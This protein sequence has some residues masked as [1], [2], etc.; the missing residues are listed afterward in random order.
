MSE[1]KVGFEVMDP[2]EVG[3]LSVVREQK[4]LVPAAQNVRFK[5][6]KAS[7]GENKSKDLK[8][9]KLE[10]RIVDGIPVNNQ[11]T[12]QVELKY[13]NKPM[14]TGVMDLVLWAD[15]SVKNR[16]DKNWWQ[17]K[18]HQV[19]LVRF[20]NAIGADIKNVTVS[21]DALQAWV[22][23]EV[24]ADVVHEAVQTLDATTGEYK[25]SGTFRERVRNFR[26]A[27]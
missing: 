19:E 27:E 24:M 8:F 11:E 6:G 15:M 17:T 16:A 14:F 1:E 18:Q 10:L 3:D 12:G 22:G 9:L 26:K 4:F 13:Q 2:I 23:A 7:I 25:D 20:L 5:I 21:D